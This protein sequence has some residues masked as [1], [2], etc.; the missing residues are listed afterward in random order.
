MRFRVRVSAHGGLTPLAGALAAA[1]SYFGEPARCSDAALKLLLEHVSG[2]EQLLATPGV[3]N[4]LC[5][6]W[7]ELAEG[8]S[9]TRL[10]ASTI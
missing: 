9:V 7:T 5:T 8:D 2:L 10:A 6:P 1:L 4:I 3:K